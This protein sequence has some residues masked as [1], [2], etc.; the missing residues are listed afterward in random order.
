MEYENRGG[1]KTGSGALA[2]SQDVAIERR[3]RL[4]RLALE[5]IDLSK[6]PYYMK[7]HLGQVECRLCSTIHTNEG[8]YLSHTQGRKHQTNLAYRASKEKNLKAVVKPPQ[9]ENADQAKPRAPRIGQPKYK[10]SKH[11]EGS[12]GTNCVYCKFH[13]QEILEDHVPGFRIMSC[14]EQKVEKPN[15]KYQYLFVGAEPYNTV[16]VRIPNTELIKQKTQTYW[17]EERKIYHIQLYLSSSKQ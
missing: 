4:R 5:S 10:V 7:N 8:S 13:F 16:G 15:P 12:T 17:D 3:E 14:W 9:S 2:S 11:R 1:H 6:D